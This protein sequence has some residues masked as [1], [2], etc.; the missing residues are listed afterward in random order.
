MEDKVKNTNVQE[1]FNNMD[2]GESYEKVD[3]CIVSYLIVIFIVYII[4]INF[5]EWIKGNEG[6]FFAYIDK[7][8]ESANGTKVEIKNCINEE[9]LCAEYIPE[10]ESIKKILSKSNGKIKWIDTNPYQRTALLNKYVFYFTELNR[11]YL[12]FFYI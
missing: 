4:F 3:E 1:I 10:S 9:V 5:Q 12:Y 7:S 2:Y 8:N 11:V 6:S